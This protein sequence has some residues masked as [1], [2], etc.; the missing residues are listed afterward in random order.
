MNLDNLN[1]YVR[2]ANLH[3]CYIPPRTNNVCYDCRLFYIL[4]GEGMLVADGCEYTVSAD[5][6]IFLPPETHYHFSFVDSDAVN[7]YTIDFDL[8]DKFSMLDNSLKTATEENFCK[9]KIRKYIVPECFSSPIVIHGACVRSYIENS[10]NGF[11]HVDQYYR[12]TASAN[13]KLALLYMLSEKKSF[14]KESALAR[15]IVEHI[16]ENASSVYLSNNTIARDLCYH[17]YHLSRVMKAY[18][19]M[20]LKE[21]ITEHRMQLAKNYLITTSMSVTQIAEACGYASYTYFI[22]SFRERYGVS[23]K[24]YRTVNRRIGL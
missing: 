24:K 21:Y 1:P 8:V 4:F 16:R 9:E 12:E 13:V 3:R 22:K 18:S 19:G 23:P 2:Y 14:G 17:P 11:V 5:T 20:T 10:V 6:L 7:I 15:K